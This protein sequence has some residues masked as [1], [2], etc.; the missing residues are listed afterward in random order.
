MLTRYHKA[1]KISDSVYWV[2]AIDWGVR[3]FHGYT[4]ARGT[5]YNAFL[6]IADKVT[7]LDTA[8][9]GFGPEVLSRIASVIDPSKIDYII[10]NHAEPDHSGSLPEVI[11]ATNPEKIF[12]SKM[13]VKTLHRYFPN[14]ELEAVG[15]GDTLDLGNKTLRFIETRMLHWP[16]SMFSYLEE[17]GILFSQD[18]FGMHLA[19]SERFDDEH[20]W[21]LLHDMSEDYYANIITLY[22]P[23]VA[24]L[25]SSLESLNL[26]LKVVAPDHGPIWRDMDRFGKLLELYQ[27]WSA[28]KTDKR[29]VIL[30]DTMWHGTEYMARSIEDGVI[31]C[32]GVQ[33]LTM[34]LSAC[35]RSDV[36]KEMLN[37][38]AV[39]VG[40]PTLNNQ[41]F[42]KVAD[43]FTYLTGLKFKTP[44]AAVFGSYGWSGE[45]VPQLK[46]MLS[47]WDGTELCG[48]I[49]VKYQPQEDDLKKCCEL[50]EHVAL[51]VL[52]YINKQNKE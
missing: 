2:G 12:A 31:K 8:K 48:E 45:G 30:Y 9:Q 17:E 20:P 40:T 28:R 14:M 4:T 25:F 23:F 43:V 46:E 34:P 7:L 35:T 41:I 1:I 19:S 39:I 38:S 26:D 49:K 11:A 37:A 29:I 36:A 51:K 32:G 22:S 15:T 21:E 18:A 6:I 5:T 24:K 16:D 47:K 13:G 52:A 10:S 44:F 50:G 42:P 27:K 3:N 33:V